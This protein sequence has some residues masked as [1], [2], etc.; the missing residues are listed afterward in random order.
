MNVMSLS[1]ILNVLIHPVILGII[2]ANVFIALSKYS[3]KYLESVFILTN[4]ETKLYY[5]H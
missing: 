5:Q 1:L 3:I 2:K 4:F